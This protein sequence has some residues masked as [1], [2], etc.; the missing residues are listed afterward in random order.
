MQ[1]SVTTGP[2]GKPGADEAGARNPQGNKRHGWDNLSYTTRVTMAFALIAAMTALV[3]IGVVSFVWEQHFQTYTRTNMQS[4]A[5]TAAREVS[6]QFSK[7]GNFDDSVI[8]IARNTKSLTP[9]IGIQVVDSRTGVEVVVYDSSE[10]I[11]ENEDGKKLDLIGPSLAPEKN[12]TNMESAP[13]KVTEGDNKI[14]TAVGSVRVWVY[15]SDTLLTS[16]D[17]DFRD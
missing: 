5:K 17:E 14:D 10:D 15:G 2:I 12:H 7:S 13:I 6:E 4:V 8:R 11:A 9:G 1:S 3:A 16:A